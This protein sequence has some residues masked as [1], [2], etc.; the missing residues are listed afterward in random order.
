MR[1][2]AYILARDTLEMPL[3]SINGRAKGNVMVELQNATIK[4]QCTKAEPNLLRE[5]NQ[6]RSKKKGSH[7]HQLHL[8]MIG[9]IPDTLDKKF[10]KLSSKHAQIRERIAVRNIQKTVK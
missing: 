9:I 4:N 10:L 6:R 3:T 7:V 1:Y 5:T 8:P 2:C